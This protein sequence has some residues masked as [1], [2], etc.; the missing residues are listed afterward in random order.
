MWLERLIVLEIHCFYLI[1]LDVLKISAAF[2]RVPYRVSE[3]SG[4]LLALFRT[5][6]DFRQ[7]GSGIVPKGSVIAPKG[8]SIAPVRVLNSAKFHWRFT[9]PYW[10]RSERTLTGAIPDRLVLLRALLALYWTLLA[11]FRT[12]LALYRTLLALFRTLLALSRTFFWR[13]SKGSRIAQIFTGTGPF[14]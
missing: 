3:G 2:K 11:L 6:F 5:L 4:F 14:T 7:K 9:G 12:L 8:S 1:R 13:K 10:Q